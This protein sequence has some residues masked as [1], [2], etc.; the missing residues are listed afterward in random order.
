MNELGITFVR[1]SDKA[2]S[3][4][5]G[6]ETVRK[7]LPRMWIDEKKCVSLLKAI[8]NYRQEYDSKRRV[9]RSSPLHDDASHWA[10]ALR[11][12]CVAL[13]L[14]MTKNNPQDVDK[15]YNEAMYGNDSSMP[16]FF[17]SNNEQ[18]PSY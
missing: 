10:D 4:D 9:Y 15:R 11:Y 1:Y 12:M 5:D 7:S 6:I 14:V 18:F 2:P 3:I 17:H 8:E 13:P 16:K